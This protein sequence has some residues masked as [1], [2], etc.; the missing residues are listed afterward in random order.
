VVENIII[1]NDSHGYPRPRQDEYYDE[2]I[3]RPLS[4]LASYNCRS[5]NSD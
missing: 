2:Y 3:L 4:A 5:F 1:V